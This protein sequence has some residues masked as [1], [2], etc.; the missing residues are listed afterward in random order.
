LAWQE[1]EEPWLYVASWSHG[2]FHWTGEPLDTFQPL[3][4]EPLTSTR[5]LCSDAST[6]VPTVY[7][8]SPDGVQRWDGIPLHADLRA[9]FA[10]TAVLSSGARGETFEGR[11]FF[12][13]KPRMSLD[14]LVLGEIVARQAIADMEQLYLSQ[15][16]QQTATMAERVR[17]AR[18]L[19]DGLLQSLAGAAL[20]LETVH[21]ILKQDQQEVR[22]R[23]RDVQRVLVAEQ[24]DLRFFIQ[25]LRPA[26]VTPPETSSSLATRLQE[27]GERIQRQWG[28]HVDMYLTHLGAELPESLAYEIYR[29]AHEAL[30]NV[31]RHAQAS[32]VRVKLEVQGEQVRLSVVDNGLGFPFQGH[33]DLAMLME[34]KLGPRTIRERVASLGGSLVIDSSASG[35]HLEIIVPLMQLGE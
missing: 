14:D 24:R 11:F 28:L 34:R 3:V 8:T 12:L 1:S 30:I 33:Y 19:H 9:R 15:R 35:A 18:D 2:K 29:M 7:Y 5:F 27:L 31:A 10:I 23:V 32:A 22:E 6:S 17:L 26:P 4:A 21:R 20:H 16:L 13:D 25:E